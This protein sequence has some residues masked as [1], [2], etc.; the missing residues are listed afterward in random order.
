[1]IT[2]GTGAARIT[3]DIAI[4]LPRPRSTEDVRLFDMHR[5]LLAELI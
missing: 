2:L 4:D 3:S 1:V 5:R